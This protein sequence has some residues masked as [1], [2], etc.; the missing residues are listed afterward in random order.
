MSAINLGTGGTFTNFLDKELGTV[1]SVPEF[2]EFPP[3][4]EAG[5]SRRSRI[6]TSRTDDYSF[7]EV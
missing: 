2:P 3:A 4:A 7:D 6:G 1:P 5:S